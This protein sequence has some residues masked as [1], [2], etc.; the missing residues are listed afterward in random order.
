[1]AA[2]TSMLR[3]LFN[4]I[5][6]D[7][8]PDAKLARRIADFKVGFIN[9][10]EDHMAFFGGN[11][12][13]AHVV[14]W[15]PKDREMFF[16]D[17]L[18][19][20]EMEVKDELLLV[21]AVKKERLVSSDS[22]NQTCMYLLHYLY[23]SDLPKEVKHRAMIDAA[24]VMH[25]RFITSIMYRDYGYPVD[26]QV[27][28]AVYSQLSYKFAIKQHG[29]WY[30]TLE[31][32][33]EDLINEKG[34]H[35]NTIVNYDDDDA[36]VYLINDTQGRIRD[37]MKNLFRELVKVLN[38][39]GRVK[40]SSNLIDLD[41]EQIFKDKTKSLTVYTRYL[42]S[43]IGDKES[44]IKGELVQV[45][46]DAVYTAP[47][48]LVEQ[49]LQW[50]SI[51]HRYTGSK[52]VEE[53]IDAVLIHS[54]GYLADHRTVFS[55]T[56]DLAGFVSRLKGVY[57]ASRMSDK[58]VIDIREKAEKI[59]RKATSTKNTGVISA[60]RTALMLYVVLRAFTMT[61]YSGVQ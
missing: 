29:S 17:V 18:Q 59:V 39:G 51:N 47:P 42:H 41:N 53:F 22:L 31:A 55:A 57:M 40:S 45:I 12:T 10:N 37:M 24:M 13:G 35:F 15:V 36:V 54:F 4:S 61:H 2:S 33:C 50:C 48:K 60:V 28:T 3:E 32:R 52:E 14:R 1:M 8:K 58:T 11:L 56:T 38:Q 34:L 21:P 16:T 44:F 30:A 5:F 6:K 9:K 49:T 46:G 19:I 23:H 25:I 27:A 26:P 20:D 43:I 7:I